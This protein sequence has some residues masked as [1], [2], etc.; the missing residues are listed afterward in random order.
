MHSD[1]IVSLNQE[2][3]ENKYS[4]RTRVMDFVW[5]ESVIITNGGDPLSE[6]LVA[7]KGAVRTDSLSADALVKAV[8]LV[9]KDKKL[10]PA[11][12]K[13]IRELK[14]KYYWDVSTKELAGVITSGKLPYAEES[15]LRKLLPTT[16]QPVTPG[17]GLC[18]HPRSN[19]HCATAATQNRPQGKTKGH[20]QISTHRERYR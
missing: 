17:A 2:G 15:A 8:E 20:R 18:S 3:E 16:N 9:R 19:R 12:K 11:M 13:A 5:G 1:V 7:I 10:L 14:N 6:E 4:W